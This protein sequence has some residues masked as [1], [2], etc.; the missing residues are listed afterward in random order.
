[1][2]WKAADAARETTPGKLLVEAEKSSTA[3]E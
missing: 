1:M 3:G 2:G